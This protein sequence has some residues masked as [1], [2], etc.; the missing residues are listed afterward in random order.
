MALFCPISHFIVLWYNYTHKP[1]KQLKNDFRGI[2]E[3]FRII[4]PYQN[5]QHVSSSTGGR[6]DR[7]TTKEK[8]P[9]QK[10]RGSPKLPKLLPFQKSKKSGKLGKLP[11]SR[12]LFTYTNLIPTLYQ[13]RKSI[14]SRKSRKSR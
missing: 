4:T 8:R 12:K 5:G 2:V 7:I 14:K 3:G 13:S 1:L 9:P 10:S 6:P 11:E